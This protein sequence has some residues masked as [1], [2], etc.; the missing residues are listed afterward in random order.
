MRAFVQPGNCCDERVLHLFRKRR[1]NSVWID[2]VIV[3]TFRLQKNLMAVALAELHDLVF[4]RRTITR[5]AACDLSRIHRRTM[6]VV[7]DDLVRG[8]RRCV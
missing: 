4:D 3:E 8:F 5:T 7:A 1:R 6:N 2:G